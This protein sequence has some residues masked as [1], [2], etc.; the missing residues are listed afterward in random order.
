MTFS[1]CFLTS[2]F[3]RQKYASL[4]SPITT[5][6]DSFCTHILFKLYFI[7][8]NS[9]SQFYSEINY[10]TIHFMREEENPKAKS[11]LSNVHQGTGF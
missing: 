11:I 2:S 1:F 5:E 10:E 8:Q 9:E 6:A 4:F 3:T 7:F